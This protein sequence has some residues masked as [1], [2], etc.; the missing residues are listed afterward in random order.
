MNRLATIV[1]I[2]AFS[3]SALAQGCD[4]SQVTALCEGALTGQNV[5]T[6]VPGFDLQIM[7]R[8]V[9]VYH[10]SFGSWTLNRVANT[11]SSTKTIAGA[12]IMSATESSVQPFS[13]NSRISDFIPEF[14]GI[15]TNITIRQAFSHTSG[16]RDSN[17]IASPTLTLRETATQLADD[18]Q[19]FVPGEGFAQPAEYFAY[20]GASM[21]AAGAAVEVATGLAWNTMFEQR[22]TGPSRLNMRNTRFVLTTPSNPRIA[23]G[24]ESTASEFGRF[25]EMLRR[26]GV[27]NGQRYLSRQSVEAM[28][29]RQSPVGVPILNTPVQISPDGADYGVG[30]WLISRD[31]SGQLRTALAAGARGFA[32]WID[33]EDQIVGTFA[34]DISSSG[35]L[36]NLYALL[37]AAAETAIRACRDCDSIDFNRDS[38]F[39]DDRDII[40]FFDALAGG[41][42]P[43]VVFCDIDFNNNGVY[44]EDQDV[45]DYFSVLAGGSCE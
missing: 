16:M 22:F 3:A 35:N 28:F 31:A 9:V 42:C 14:D 26:G 37:I 34:T 41:P 1:G 45:I 6:P 30:V 38:V 27:F 18:P 12:M 33:F 5:N 24:C 29:T 21:H 23:G 2:G 39:P 17:I 25:M 40:N 4:F 7:H 36:Q 32:S 43:H 13:L 44:P 8:G 20:G 10:R 11:D 15:K 19:I